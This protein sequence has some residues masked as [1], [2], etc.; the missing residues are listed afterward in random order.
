MRVIF[1]KI[2]A[3]SSKWADFLHVFERFDTREKIRYIHQFLTGEGNPGSVPSARFARVA[4][5]LASRRTTMK[6]PSVGQILQGASRTFLRF[7]LVLC[8]AVVGTVSAVILM[9]HEGPE[10]ATAL[11]SILFASILGIPLLFGLAVI[12]EKRGWGRWKSLGVQVF[13]IA[14]LV[15]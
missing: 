15:V 12:A 3:N 1:L 9:D 8:S 2:N 14:L 10:V 5:F 4:L 6:L 7:P 13:G 11:F